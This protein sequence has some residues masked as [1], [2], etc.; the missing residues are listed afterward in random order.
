MKDKINILGEEWTIRT[1]KELEDKDG[2]TD[3]TIREIKICKTLYREP[4]GNDCKGRNTKYANEVA[5][6]ELLHAIMHE[7]GKWYNYGIH[8]EENV[9]L[10]AITYPKMKAI[11]KELGVEE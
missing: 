1:D 9:N 2:E 7:L 11:F 4:K 5:R 6:H 3:H 8:T 10:L